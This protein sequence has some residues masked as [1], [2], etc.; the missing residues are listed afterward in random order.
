MEISMVSIG[1]KVGNIEEN[2]NHVPKRPYF[3]GRERGVQTLE[4]W[5]SWGRRR[6][7]EILGTTAFGIFVWGDYEKR[8]ENIYSY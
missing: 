1:E 8:Y 5:T 7:G 4:T 2:E 6:S 3:M